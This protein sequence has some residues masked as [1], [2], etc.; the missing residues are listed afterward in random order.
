MD[1]IDYLDSTGKELYS[2]FYSKYVPV[3][4]VADSFHSI[5]GFLISCGLIA[6]LG[7]AGYFSVKIFCKY[8]K[9]RW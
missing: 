6:L 2:Q 1:F 4:T 8:F 9:I 3:D 5:L 7:C